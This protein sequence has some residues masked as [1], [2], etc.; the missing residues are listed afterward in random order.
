MEKNLDSNGTSVDR[1]SIAFPDFG[2]EETASEAILNEPIN[3][4]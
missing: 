2:N 4:F 3:P 1:K